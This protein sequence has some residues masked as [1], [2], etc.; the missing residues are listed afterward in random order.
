MSWYSQEESFNVD[1]FNERENTGVLGRMNDV[2]GNSMATG[3]I[4]ITRMLANL[5]G[6][7]SLGRK[8]DVL[9]SRGDG[10]NAFD[11]G[12][13]QMSVFRH[14]ATSSICDSLSNKVSLAHLRQS[15]EFVT[16]IRELNSEHE[17]G[18]GMHANLWSQA[19]IDSDTESEDY[20]A[21]LGTVPRITANSNT[22]PYL[23]DTHVGN[24]LA[25]ILR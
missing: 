9:S 24:Q 25:Q 7:P 15:S 20:R 16:L 6:D 21:D 8:V 10:I 13:S 2:L 14:P 19:L 18:S 11:P 1:A 3:Q 23:P 17:T 5:V 4:A 12:V 22:P